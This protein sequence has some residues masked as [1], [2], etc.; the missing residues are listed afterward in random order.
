MF[1]SAQP[2]ISPGAK[3]GLIHAR[4]TITS[5]SLNCTAPKAMGETAS[6]ATIYTAD[7]T[8][9][10][11]TVSVLIFLISIPPVFYFGDG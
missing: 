9:V 7:V 2:K 5:D 1:A 6:V 10:K 3:A 11:A 4:S 8:P